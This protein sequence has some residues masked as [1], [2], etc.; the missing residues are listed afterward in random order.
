M[1]GFHTRFH[2]RPLISDPQMAKKPTPAA[3]AKNVQTMLKKSG[4]PTD[5]KVTITPSKKK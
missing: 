5:S 3:T 2:V 4:M 1:A